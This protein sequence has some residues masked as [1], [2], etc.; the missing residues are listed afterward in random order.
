MLIRSSLGLC[1]LLSIPFSLLADSNVRVEVIKD[2]GISIHRP[3]VDTPIFAFN[4]PVDGRSYVHP[5]LAPDGKGVLTEFAPGHHKHQTGIYVG[6]LKVN[7]RDYFHNRGGDHF[8]RR[9]FDWKNDSQGVRWTSTYEL[10]DKDKDA[11]LTETQAWLFRDF[12]KSYLIDL[13]LTL[14]AETDVTFDKHDYGGLFLRMPFKNQVGAKAINSEGHENAKAEGQKARWVDIG[15]TV[16]GRKDAGH[17]AVM[18]HDAAPWRVDGQLG[19]GPSPSRAG[20][21]KIAKGASVVLR[22]RFMVYTGEFQQ[23]QVEAE[24]KAFSAI[25]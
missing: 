4:A 22:Y 5:L 16:D 9:A 8:R 7:G 24:S 15:M 20:A 3:G 1:V 2:G 18:S 14:K 17:I 25:K 23:E 10:L 19:V 11:Q 6:F 12:T 21:W 13:T